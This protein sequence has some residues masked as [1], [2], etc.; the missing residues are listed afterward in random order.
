LDFE[1][2]RTNVERAVA[3]LERTVGRRPLGWFS[4]GGQSEHTR[5]ILAR[6]GFLYDSDGLNDDLPYYTVAMGKPWLVV[7][8]A[9]DTNDFKFWR[10]GWSAGSDFLS[11]LKDSFD[12]LYQEGAT[13]PRLLSVGLHA[14]IGG[15]PGRAAAIARFIRY[16]K[17]HDKVWFA[18]RD[19]IARH[20]MEAHPPGRG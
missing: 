14:R 4:R 13:R 18:G 9:L 2:E 6:S 17:G 11:Y 7:P 5:E 1:A 10:G 20:W 8:Y 15:R 3:S 16:A 12:V 19:D